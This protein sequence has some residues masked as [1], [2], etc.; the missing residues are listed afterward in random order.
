MYH[1][2]INCDETASSKSTDWIA[3]MPATVAKVFSGSQ[4]N[5]H[6]ICKQIITP[7]S[8]SSFFGGIT[9]STNQSKD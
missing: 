1:A 7:S 6:K 2:I 4:R 9:E 3:Q 5:G 8:Q